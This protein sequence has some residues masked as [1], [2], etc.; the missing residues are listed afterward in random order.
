MYWLVCY[1]MCQNLFFFC[2]DLQVT[3]GL[4]RNQDPVI[5]NVCCTFMKLCVHREHFSQIQFLV[6]VVYS[7]NDTLMHVSHSADS[8]SM[9]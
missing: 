6:L 2:C 3:T 8:L 4:F 5:G 9:I 1:I 7:G